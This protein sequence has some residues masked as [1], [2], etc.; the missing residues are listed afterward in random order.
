[1]IYVLNIVKL[2]DFPQ[3]T[4][5]A[6]RRYGPESQVTRQVLCPPATSRAAE[7]ARPRL[8]VTWQKF[9]WWDVAMW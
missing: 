3:E 4:V 5:S 2:D 1:M 7:A 9:F 6:A 8:R